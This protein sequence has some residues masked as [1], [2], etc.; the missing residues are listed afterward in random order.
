MMVRC[1]ITLEAS[2]P[3]HQPNLA[4]PISVTGLFLS[5]PRIRSPRHFD[6]DQI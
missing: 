4:L 6:L 1:G 3:H 5:R 2:H